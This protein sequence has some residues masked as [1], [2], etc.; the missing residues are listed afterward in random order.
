MNVEKM[1]GEGE[2]FS[3]VCLALPLRTLPSF[4]FNWVNVEDVF[5]CIH[6]DDECCRTAHG[7]DGNVSHRS[8]YSTVQRSLARHV[9]T[10]S[11]RITVAQTFALIIAHHYST[12][13]SVQTSDVGTIVHLLFAVLALPDGEALAE[14][15][16]SQCCNTET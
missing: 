12:H 7:H 8:R 1:N 6:H 2:R 15:I 5:Q 13:T 14:E 16:Q 10:V 3:F 9:L 4:S 11:T